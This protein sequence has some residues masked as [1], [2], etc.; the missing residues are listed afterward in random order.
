MLAPI[1]DV[2]METGNESQGREDEDNSTKKE[3]N[4]SGTNLE[5]GLLSKIMDLIDIPVHRDDTR[6]P[7]VDITSHD[8]MVGN[9][10]KGK[11][12]RK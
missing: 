9:S 3:L 7:L 2:I 11:V 8:N 12:S 1:Q 10:G 5:N 4:G 6:I